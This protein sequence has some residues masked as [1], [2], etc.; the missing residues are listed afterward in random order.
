MQQEAAGYTF[1]VT[2]SGNP[3]KATLILRTF[4]LPASRPLVATNLA[5]CQQKLLLYIA[6]LVLVLCM[7]TGTC[8]QPE[9]AELHFL[10]A[11][12]SLSAAESAEA[13]DSG[14]AVVFNPSLVVVDNG[15]WLLTARSLS[16]EMR[17][18]I[19]WWQSVGHLCIG[20]LLQPPQA[21]AGS[22]LAV[23]DHPTTSGL[24]LPELGRHV[25]TLFDPWSASHM[26]Y[27]ECI[28]SQPEPLPRMPK[29]ATGLEDPKLFV[30]PGRGVY[31]TF[32]R[33][34]QVAAGAAD[35]HCGN[36]AF[37]QYVVTVRWV[38]AAAR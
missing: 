25:C 3:A 33:K 30:W 24:M 37:V 16:K 20:D 34:P 12:L 17:E 21:A 6:L 4:I 38:G 5:M 13:A 10:D 7:A 29:D 1:T 35:A 2:Q 14:H 15:K 22:L 36:P 18:G 31:A 32:N 9:K 11:P 27:N 26:P 8:S 23:E 19:Q 28:K